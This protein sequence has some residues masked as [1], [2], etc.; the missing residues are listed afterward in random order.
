MCFGDLCPGLPSWVVHLCKAIKVRCCIF[1][2]EQMW[3]WGFPFGSVYICISK[4]LNTF[5]CK[6]M[7]Q[8]WLQIC[9]LKH[10][11]GQ[12]LSWFEIVFSWLERLIPLADLLTNVIY[13][14]CRKCFQHD[15]RWQAHYDLIPWSI[16][17]S[18]MYKSHYLQGLKS[19]S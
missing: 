4:R 17:L 18:S 19:H 1:L 14:K 8:N 16:C 5:S 15:R 13:Y 12:G 9:S 2:G 10:P 6:H 7:W 3:N 11:T